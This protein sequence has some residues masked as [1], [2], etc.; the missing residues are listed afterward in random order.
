[1]IGLFLS[2][3]FSN[4]IAWWLSSRDPHL[5]CRAGLQFTEGHKGGCRL[6]SQLG[7]PLL[8]PSLQTLGFG[9]AVCWDSLTWGFVFLLN[10]WECS[11]GDKCCKAHLCSHSYSFWTLGKQQRQCQLFLRQPVWKDIMG[12]GTRELG[13]VTQQ[14]LCDLGKNDITSLGLSLHM[15]DTDIHQCLLLR[16]ATV[17]TQ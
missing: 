10:E 11:A 4:P 2:R 1:M 7:S 6:V 3:L 12:F 5:F 8:W 16:E 17:R 9:A 14:Q 15:C 13:F